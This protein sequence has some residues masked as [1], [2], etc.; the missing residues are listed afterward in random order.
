MLKRYTSS[1]TAS[2]ISWLHWVLSR[3]KSRRSLRM[4][5][6]FGG[7]SQLRSPAT[8]PRSAP[9]DLPLGALLRLG[10]AEMVQPPVHQRAREPARAAR[11]APELGDRPRIRHPEQPVHDHRMRSTRSA[12]SGLVGVRQHREVVHR[13]WKPSGRASRSGRMKR[14]MSTTTTTAPM[15]D[16]AQQLPGPAGGEDV[17]QQ[18][19]DDRARPPPAAPGRERRPRAPRQRKERPAGV[20]DAVRGE[21]RQRQQRHH[22]RRVHHRLAPAWPR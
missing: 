21:D 17:H 10:E 3:K 4:N 15:A 16:Q 9:A 2:R 1:S 5:S 12:A 13:F 20:H 18:Q 6:R 7:G 8:G 19:G 22:P 14:S 11:R